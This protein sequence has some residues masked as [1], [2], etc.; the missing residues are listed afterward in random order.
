MMLGLAEK[1]GCELL[2][3]RF[4]DYLQ[5]RPLLGAERRW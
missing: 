4:F 2:I 3:A 1:S 5:Q